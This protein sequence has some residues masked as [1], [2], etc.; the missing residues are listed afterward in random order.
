MDIYSPSRTFGAQIEQRSGNYA[1]V[2]SRDISLI[3]KSAKTAFDYAF[4][5]LAS[6]IFTYFKGQ[7]VIKL[8][9]KAP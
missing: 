6:V 2:S 4:S 3:I 5:T 9:R 1:S 7:S 8:R